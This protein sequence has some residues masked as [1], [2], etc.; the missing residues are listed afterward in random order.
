MGSDGSGM[1]RV[2]LADTRSRAPQRHTSDV[3]FGGLPS[4]RVKLTGSTTHRGAR[5]PRPDT[6]LQ[7]HTRR[8]HRAC[9]QPTRTE[10]G[11]TLNGSLQHR[12]GR[13]HLLYIKER[14]QVGGPH[15]AAPHGMRDGIHL[16]AIFEMSLCH[17]SG[18]RVRHG[19]RGREA[20]C[21]NGGVAGPRWIPQYSIPARVRV[22]GPPRRVRAGA[23]QASHGLT[24]NQ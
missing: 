4:G 19:P 15:R 20:G 23:C 7:P 8:Q 18:G 14:R 9:M 11:R 3:V 2:T 6:S 24:S 12:T 1:L 17:E 5:P 10:R 16:Q 13:R 21:W 22:P